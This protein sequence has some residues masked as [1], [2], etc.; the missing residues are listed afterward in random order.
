M[1]MY[2]HHLLMMISIMHLNIGV[3]ITYVRHCALS[4]MCVG[5]YVGVCVC[6]RARA[7]YLAKS[8]SGLSGNEPRP[9]PFSIK[10]VYPILVISEAGFTSIYL[11]IFTNIV[12]AENKRVSYFLDKQLLLDFL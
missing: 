2:Y 1:M 4:Y 5:G 3:F 7:S 10:R 8:L 12:S 9:K 6:A 11:N